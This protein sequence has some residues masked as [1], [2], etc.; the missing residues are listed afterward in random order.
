MKKPYRM[1]LLRK[2]GLSVN[3]LLFIFLKAVLNG[4]LLLSWQI[5]HVSSESLVGCKQFFLA[6]SYLSSHFDF[7][8]SDYSSP[9][10]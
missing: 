6:H 2:S 5:L 7:A 9:G 10:F 3:K 1:V 4:T 8:A